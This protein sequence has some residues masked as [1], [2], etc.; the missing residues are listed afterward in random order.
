MKSRLKLAVGG[1][2][3]NDAAA[4]IEA[5]DRAEQGDLVEDRVVSF[6]SW[7]GLSA[8]MSGPR[9]ALLRH[10]HASPEASNEDLARALGRDPSRVAADVEALEEAG[11]VERR[12]TALHVTTDAIETQILL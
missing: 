7:E 1:S 4:F 11:L 9:L 2:A 5:W 8:I 6:E 12:G 10:L 3:L